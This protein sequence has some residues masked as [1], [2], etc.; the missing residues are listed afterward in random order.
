MGRRFQVA[1]DCSDPERLARFWADFLG[2]RLADPP[3]GHATWAE[4]SAS[5]GGP[6]E[7]WA[8]LVDPDRVGPT[9]LFHRVP[10]PKVVKNRVHLDFRVGDPATSEAGRREAVDAE[11]R[12]LVGRGATHVR[13]DDDDEDYYAVMQDPE[14]N[15]FCIG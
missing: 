3:D 12:R 4:Y 14:G 13:T 10:E 1:I 11:A 5:A 7:S 15:E 9:I 2:Y 8:Q 6:D